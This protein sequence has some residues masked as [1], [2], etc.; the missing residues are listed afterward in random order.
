MSAEFDARLEFAQFRRP[1]V[2][3]GDPD[4][5]AARR[6]FSRADVISGGAL[7]DEQ[8]IRGGATAKNRDR[9]EL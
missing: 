3:A 8:V 9:H 4:Y 7:P 1:P 6:L 5:D 2:V